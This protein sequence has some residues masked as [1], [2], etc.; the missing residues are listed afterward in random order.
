MM[1]FCFVFFIEHKNELVFF[2]FDDHF[3]ALKYKL[4]ISIELNEYNKKIKMFYAIVCVDFGGCTV[5]FLRF[6]NS[7]LLIAS[8]VLSR[9]LGSKSTRI[10]RNACVISSCTSGHW[11]WSSR[12]ICMERSGVCGTSVYLY[13]MLMNFF[14]E[15]IK[16]HQYQTYSNP[17]MFHNLFDG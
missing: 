6:S 9:T 7:W 13:I 5:R 14:V 16:F 3:T 4:N 8:I 2:F 15:K 1:R 11:S 12:N 17:I 10:V